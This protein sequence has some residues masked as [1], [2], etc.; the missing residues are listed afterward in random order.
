MQ[1]GN[2]VCIICEHFDRCSIASSLLKS[3]IKSVGRELGLNNLSVEVEKVGI[4]V[5]IEKETKSHKM[6]GVSD[7]FTW[8]AM[9]NPFF[10]DILKTNLR[11]IE[12]RLKLKINQEDRAYERK[13]G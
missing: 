7:E 1:P 8:D 12:K 5:R 13:K 10:K 11:I 3:E 9:K 4:M 6:F 2:K